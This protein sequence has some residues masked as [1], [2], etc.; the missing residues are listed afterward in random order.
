MRHFFL[1]LYTILSRRL[2]GLQSEG[3]GNTNGGLKAHVG[4]HRRGD[5]QT[6]SC[7]DPSGSLEVDVC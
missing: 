5:A 3:V 2:H 6:A 4:D 7:V 1:S